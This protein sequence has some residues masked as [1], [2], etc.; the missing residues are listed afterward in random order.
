MRTFDPE[1]W[2]PTEKEDLNLSLSMPLRSRKKI[3]EEPPEK[4]EPLSIYANFSQWKRLK[5]ATAYILRAVKLFKIKN[6][7]QQ[8]NAL[9]SEIPELTATEYISAEKFLCEETQ[10]AFPQMRK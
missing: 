9:V 1:N 3:H 7:Q 2:S 6:K 4:Y 5:A 8:M 10:K